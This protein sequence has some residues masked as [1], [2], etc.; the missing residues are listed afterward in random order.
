MAA[1]INPTQTINTLTPPSSSHGNPPGGMWEFAV[2]LDRD[3]V[4]SAIYSIL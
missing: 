1:T 3:E 2:P 4:S